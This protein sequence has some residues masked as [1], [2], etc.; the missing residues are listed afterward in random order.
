MGGQV[1]LRKH[2]LGSPAKETSG[3]GKTKGN[4]GLTT[5]R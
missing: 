5:E 2:F 1:T 3:I 4:E